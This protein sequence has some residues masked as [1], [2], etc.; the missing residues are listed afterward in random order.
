M[1]V[2]E[3][4]RRMVGMRGASHPVLDWTWR[5]AVILFSDLVGA[6]AVNNFLT[7]AHI[8]AGGVTGVAQILHHYAPALGVGT[9]YFVFNIPLFI[10]GY[11][12]L[13]RRFIFQTG[14]AILGFSALADFVRLHFATPTDPLLMGLYGGVLTGL[15]S[16][17]VIRVGGSMGGTDIVSLVVHRLTG[18]N[19]GSVSFVM[20]AAIVLLSML[21]FGVPAGL[22]TL[23][24]M[25]AASRVVSGLMHF[26]QRKTAL[27]V[28]SKPSEV[29]SAIGQ[30]LVRGSTV[31][32]AYG[33]YTQRERGVLLCAMTHLEIAD[34]KEIVQSLDPDAFITILDTTEV[35]GRF[36]QS[37]P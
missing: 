19:I 23:V 10:L 3:D 30:R 36:R 8:L 29:A 12:Y 25:Y 34:L 16:G 37:A 31:M 35:I 24:S 27:I 5:I 22:Y 32:R 7:P 33:A 4:M 21:V 28:T 6:V 1:R 14:I 17:L 20:N 2:Y 11:R 13:G 18:R 15:S 26:Q 9:M